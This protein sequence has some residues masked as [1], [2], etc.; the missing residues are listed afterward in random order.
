[1]TLKKAFEEIPTI[2][3]CLDVG[4]AKFGKLL[5]HIHIHDNIGGDSEKQDLHLPIGDGKINFK[6]I[7]EKLKETKYSGNITLEVYN[8]DKES[9]KISITRVRELI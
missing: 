7:F 5:K 4:H 1:M 6:P 8:P 9:R 3:F 2:Y